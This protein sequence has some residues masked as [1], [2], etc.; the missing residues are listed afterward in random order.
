MS[1]RNYVSTDGN[2]RE[3]V[4]PSVPSPGHSQVTVTDSSSMI[5][6]DPRKNTIIGFNYDKA[7]EIM[8]SEARQQYLD[9]AKKHIDLDNPASIRSYGQELI[10]ESEKVTNRVLAQSQ[11]DPAVPLIKLTNE[12]M[13]T[14]DNISNPAEPLKPQPAWKRLPIVRH[15]VKK[16]KE[17][18][19]EHRT[20]D[21][22][23]D[24]IGGKFV[25]MKTG[26][27]TTTTN[28]DDIGE[29]CRDCVIDAREKI[30]EL[31][32]VRE[33]LQKTI[34]EMDAQDVCD[35]DELQKL[36]TRDR[37]LSKRIT[38]LTTSEHLFQQNM[39]QLNQI[40]RNYSGVI[41]KC[42]ESLQLIPVVKIQATTGVE[43]EKQRRYIEAIKS[44]EDY[45]NEAIR[46]N[47][48]ELRDQ[49]M[50]LSKMIETPGLKIESIEDAKRAIIDM[51][52]GYEQMAKDGEKMRI[53]MRS[54][55]QKMTDEL[56][57]EL[58]KEYI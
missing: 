4:P 27:M 11:S 19:I 18:Q 23:L 51:H 40:Q 54:A 6:T 56:H 14:L 21:K 26:A 24:D 47:A 39:V 32:L 33:E 36:R 45:A 43:I 9:E 41:D 49:T 35:L 16:V 42:E 1:E 34:R 13:M 37:E 3:P 2:Y 10:Q 25:A 20:P 22:N 5:V 38:S 15:F 46:K 31:M 50:E 8:S 7:L 28:I 17:V 52:R 57:E 55:L 12:L 53:E 44:F 30:I 29:T 58:R 48:H